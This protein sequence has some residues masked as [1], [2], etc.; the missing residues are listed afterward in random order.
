MTSL[1]ADLPTAPSWDTPVIAPSLV[2]APGPVPVSIY[3]DEVWSLAPLVANP[4]AYRP[5]LYWAR[6]PDAVRPQMRLAAWTMINTPLPASVLVGHPAWHSRLGPHGLRD[7]VLRWQYF[8]TWLHQQELGGLH[9]VTD[10]ALAAYAG[11]LARRPGAGRSSV[12]KDLVALTRLWAFDTASGVPGGMPIP[13]WHQQGIDDYLPAAAAGRGENATEPISAAT[14]GPLLVWA[15]RVVDDFADDIF[16]AR[17]E[18][19]RLA[20]A[21]ESTPGT[22]ETRARLKR[23]LQDLIDRGLPVPS[24]HNAG[25][26][27]A[28]ANIYIAAQ[29]GCPATQVNSLLATAPWQHLLPYVRDNP[30]PCPLALPVTGRIDGEPWTEFIDFTETRQLLRHVGTA[31]FIVLAYLTGMRPAEVLGLETGC[32]PDP[33]SSRHLIYG[34]VFKNAS[35]E[36]GNHHSAGHPREVP[37]VAIPPVVRAIR[38]LERIAPDNGLLFDAAAH[39][40]HTVP[41]ASYTSISNEGMRSRIEGFVAWASEL[42]RRLEREHEVIPDDPH[43]AVGLARFRRTLAWHIAR[44]PGGLVALAIQYGHMRTTMSGGY[45]ARGRGGIHE[46][47]DVETARSTAETLTTLHQDLTRGVGISGP[48]ARRAIHAASQAPTFAGSIRTLRQARDLLGNPALTVHD[49]PGALLMCVYDRERALCHRLEP[50]DAPRLDRCRPTCANVARTDHHADLLLQH[51]RDL[52]QQAASEAVPG[53]LADRL[54]RRAGQLRALSDRH[55]H[56]CIR[57]QEPTS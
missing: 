33:V 52:E 44:R 49:N 42:A 8:T 54:A 4:S 34:R 55:A 16:A 36:D 30:G 48:A 43:G 50:V 13:P 21:A 2:V 24:R 10:E 14:M 23:Y 17:A 29:A 26:R 1:P 15:L 25:H 19:R 35:D 46:L 7:T 22:P 32:C 56:E 31:C 27:H 47:L 39:S 3:A 18:S 12:T 5:S 11:H 45:A 38:L 28:L 40:F 37:W 51:A 9:E 53:P 57:T 6:F 41:T 20:E